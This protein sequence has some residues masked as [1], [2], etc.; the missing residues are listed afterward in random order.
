MAL[1]TIFQLYQDGQFYWWRK[2]EYLQKT[3]DMQQVTYNFYHIMLYQEHLTVSGIR[4]YNISGNRQWYIGSCISN[5]HMITTPT[6]QWYKELQNINQNNLH[7]N[8][9]FRYFFLQ[10][11]QLRSWRWYWILIQNDEYITHIHNQWPTTD[12]A[13]ILSN[14]QP[15]VKS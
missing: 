7:F 5:Y 6:L 10:W 8:G 14:T 4:T 3:N 12:Y 15:E 1:S 2:M 11:G 9:N 13:V